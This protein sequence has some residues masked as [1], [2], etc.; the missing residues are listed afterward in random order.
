LID[1]GG[2]DGN[3]LAG[4]SFVY[5]DTKKDALMKRLDSHITKFEG[6]AGKVVHNSI[7]KKAHQHSPDA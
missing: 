2:L 6:S 5:Y 4:K 1:K 7:Y 3:D